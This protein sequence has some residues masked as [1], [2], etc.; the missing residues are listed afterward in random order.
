[1][2][3]GG[4]AGAA[5]AGL[6]DGKT[7]AADGKKPYK[8]T[9]VK[10][11]TTICPYCGCGCGIVVSTRDGKIVNAEGDPA[12]P[13]NEG[14]LCSKGAGLYQVVQNEGRLRK[15]RYRA[16]GSDKWEEKTWDWAIEKIAQKIKATRDASFVDKNEKGQVV[17]RTTGIACL[18]GAALDNE[19]CM[20]LSKFARSLGLVNIE[21]QARICHSSTVMGLGA[22]FGRGAMTNHWIDIQHADVVMVIGSN[23][24]RNHTMSFRWAIK[25]RDRGATLITIDPRFTATA[26]ASDLFAPMRSGTDIAFIG[27]I[28]NYLLQNEQINKDYVL[29]HTNASFIITPEYDFTDGL[30]SGYEPGSR[31]YNKAGWSFEKD[32]QGI[33]KRDLTLQD[34]RCVYRMMKQHYSRYTPGM[35]SNICGTTEDVFLEVC[36]AVAATSAPDKAMTILYAMGTTQHTHGSQNIRAYAVMQLLL[37]NIGV[38]GGG[39]NAMRGESNVQGS[40]DAGLL[41]HLLPGYLPSPTDDD[42]SL[43]VYK[44]KNTPVCP[45]THSANWWGNRQK[46]MVSLLKAWW[47][48]HATAENDFAYHYIPKRDKNYSHIAVFEAMN[49]GEI[50]GMMVFGQNP[51]VSG[52]NSNQERGALEKLDWMV[53]VDLW[54]TDTA[55]FWKRPDVD[56]KTIGTEVFLLPAAASFEKEGSITNSGRWA[57]W[58]YQVV[59]PIGDAKPDLWIMDR[60]VR[61]LKKEYSPGGVFPDP[62]VNLIWDYGKA[63]PDPHQVARET[64]GYF[65]ADVE[66][67]E[68][69]KSFKK[70]DQVPSFAFLKDDGA[71]ACSNWIMAG[72]Y[73]SRDPETGNMMARRDNTDAPNNIGLYPRWA[74][75]WPANRRILYNRASCNAEGVPYN[76]KK[77]V[78][79]WDAV[80][81]QWIGDVPDGPWPPMADRKKGKYA[82]IMTTEGLAYLFSPVPADGPF[83]EHYE[84]YESPVANLLNSQ[85]FNPAVN[86]TIWTNIEQETGTA[87]EFPIVATTFRLAE[88]W[89]AG[90]M[91]RNQPWLVELQP[92]AF[93]LI[94][95]ELAEK[96]GI[97]HGDKVKIRSARGEIAVYG[98][99]TNRVKPF[100]L[101]GRKVHQIA[102]PWHWGYAGLATGDSANLLT[103]HIGDANTMI[104]E[105]KVFLCDVSRA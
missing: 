24:T 36:R 49:R 29:T 56:P 97:K 5:A 18:G 55:V 80:S 30:F 63:D 42:T 47:G 65:L 82:F 66:F 37:G 46:Y 77:W 105:Y 28:I 87:E 45:D 89:Q 33:V 92:N 79:K 7:A 59:D 93:V 76:P 58:R 10:E 22:S 13:I 20:T 26:A 83:P 99:V 15:V 81:G 1:M 25:A 34:P 6:V 35:V 91:T 9:G 95:R 64:N 88:H 98:V 53:V 69:K 102:I 96:K 75:S 61:S 70:G 17:N 60:L 52:P 19:E 90:A 68:Q 84:P 21:H 72:S 54:E 94:D 57:Q 100:I 101:S 62:I 12:H 2:V 51:V 40:T 11:I 48:D 31:T 78:V 39:I 23:A 32:E 44:E 14:A 103:P 41:F 43:Q 104:P 85:P 27:G 38:A 73:I 74:W 86:T 71:T 16:P 50:K 4:T 67:P 8:L 3:V